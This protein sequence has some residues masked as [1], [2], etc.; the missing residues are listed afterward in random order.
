MVEYK[1]DLHNHTSTFANI[2]GTRQ[3]PQPYVQ[4]LLNS[5]LNKKGNIVLGIADFNSDGRYKKF[6]ETVKIMPAYIVDT[7]YEEYFISIKKGKKKM[8]VVR[9]DEIETEKGHILIL[10]LPHAIKKRHLK[11]I[12]QE[13]KKERCVV[14][15]NHPLH[16]FPIPHFLV[17]RILGKSDEALSIKE[18][19]LEKYLHLFDALELNPYFPEDWKN[20][21][22][23]ARKW[24]KPLVTNSDA[25]FI[26]E[27]FRSYFL[28]KDIDF[29]SPKKY[30]KSLKHAFKKQIR[31]HAAKSGFISLYKHGVQIVF[32]T[33][34]QKLGLLS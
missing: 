8:Y 16:A 12:L 6:L 4:H 33:L 26:N 29:S 17:L 13:A 10:G 2:L 25:H 27:F 14:I 23:F 21:K 19:L 24:Q 15:A 3:N 22:R 34:A 5:L 28:L 9:A 30:K 31:I 18:R 7:H 11:N 32:Q 20:I 1:L